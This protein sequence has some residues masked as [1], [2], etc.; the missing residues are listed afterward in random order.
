MAALV[1]PAPDVYVAD[2]TWGVDFGLVDDEGRLLAD[3]VHYRDARRAAAVE[4]VYERVPPRELYERTGI[5]LLPINT[6][7]ELAALVAENDPALENAERLL[8]IPDLVHSRLCGS[9]STE[10]T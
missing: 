10:L 5:Q 7:F 2:A 6:V 3:P 4:P 1:A 8:L 9:H